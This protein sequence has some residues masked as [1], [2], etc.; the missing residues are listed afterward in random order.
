MSERDLNQDLIEFHAEFDSAKPLM[1]EVCG[2]A[3]RLAKKLWENSKL[4]HGLFVPTEFQELC[5][6]II[7]KELENPCPARP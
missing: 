4:R 3:E 1:V 6:G 2:L 7:Q 5:R